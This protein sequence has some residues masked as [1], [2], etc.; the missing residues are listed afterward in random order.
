MLGRR[1]F[2]LDNR[3]AGIVRRGVIAVILAS[4]AVLSAEPT[5][6]G[7]QTLVTT[8]GERSAADLVSIQADLSMTVQTEAGRKTYLAEEVLRWGQ[9]RQAGKGP[10]VLL[11]DGGI[12]VSAPA[13]L[14]DE[15]LLLAADVWGGISLP[16]EWVRG[17]VFWPPAD[18][19]QRDR[20]MDRLAR[21]EGQSDQILLENGDVVA[22]TIT[23]L[24]AD[25]LRA[26]LESGQSEIP[27]T[28]VTAVI[29][30]PSLVAAAQ[31]KPRHA[32]V[33][34]RDGSFLKADQFVLGDGRMTLRLAG[35]VTLQSAADVDPAREL[36][37]VMYFGPHVRYLSELTPLDYKHIP[38]L[39]LGWDYG[40]DRNVLGG[41]L[42]QS[43]VV[44][45]KGIAL[46]ST[47]R[48]AYTLDLPYR[49]FEAEL[50]IDDAARGGGS[51]VFRVLHDGG[52]GE[53]QDAYRSPVIRGGMPPLPIRVDLAGAKRLVLIVEFADRGDQLDHANW[54]NARLIP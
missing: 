54:L 42:R 6:R 14:S 4:P 20:L 23:G 8:R 19:L 30:D 44:Y 53:W 41:R 37:L 24:N 45:P 31:V 39:A 22:G 16:L 47:A 7:P 49:R 35:G 11:A 12:L 52:N 33:G 18:L 9:A 25:S 2:S 28:R 26:E 17:I 34:L 10:L 46:H 1:G 40:A 27:L 3:P 38:Y 13:D 5:G 48:L 21:A 50:A 15:R 29:F 32:L 43:G 36:V 51:V